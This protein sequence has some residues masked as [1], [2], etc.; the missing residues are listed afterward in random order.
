MRRG[1]P[2]ALG[3]IDRISTAHLGLMTLGSHFAA[4]GNLLCEGAED[5]AVDVGEDQVAPGVSRDLV[6]GRQGVVYR[7]GRQ[8]LGDPFPDEERGF[9]GRAPCT[10]ESIGQVVD[11]EVDPDEDDAGG[12]DAGAAERGFLAACV[13][14]R[15]T[16]NTG[17]PERPASRYGRV[18]ATGT[19]ENDLL[20]RGGY[21]L[22]EIIDQPGTGNVAGARGRGNSPTKSYAASIAPR[23]APRRDAIKTARH[24]GGRNDRASGSLKRR[25]RGGLVDSSPRWTAMRAAVRLASPC[26]NWP[27]F[28]WP[29]FDRLWFDWPPSF[30]NP[31]G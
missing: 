23:T 27:Y 31:I 8:V 20:D 14:G 19:E 4:S 30:S 24:D 3:A 22:D 11:L 26:F 2:I 12:V 9:I 28:N 13:P 29:W 18:S 21:V 7:L 5:L 17:T 6:H 16:S 1:S 15:S 25:V 10:S